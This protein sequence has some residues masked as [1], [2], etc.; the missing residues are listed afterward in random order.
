MT[1]TKLLIY[2][3]F[4]I[5]LCSPDNNGVAGVF[6][7]IWHFFCSLSRTSGN[8]GENNDCLPA[9]FLCLSWIAHHKQ[10]QCNPE[11]YQGG[12]WVA[13]SIY[14]ASHQ[15]PSGSSVSN[16]QL[17]F[18]CL[19]QGLWQITISFYFCMHLNPRLSFYFSFLI[20][21][22]CFLEFFMLEAI[23][24]TQMLW[25]SYIFKVL[26]PPRKK[27][28]CI[29]PH[30]VTIYVSYEKSQI[31]FATVMITSLIMLSV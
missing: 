27:R 8:C 24:A 16:E 9:C 26:K 23:G 21:C 4:I 17:V 5:L 3:C 12:C 10:S 7:I 6:L 13:D 1:S 14:T 31:W 11:P 22:P 20:F 30:S 19:T 28:A 29:K 15:W 18:K 25:K 2:N